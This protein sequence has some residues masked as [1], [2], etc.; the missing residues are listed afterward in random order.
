M[1][2]DG[3]FG[4]IDKAGELVIPAI[5]DHAFDFDRYNHAI[6]QFN[7]IDLNYFDETWF[8]INS[9]GDP[10]ISAHSILWSNGPI[11]ALQ[12][13]NEYMFFDVSNNTFLDQKS[14]ELPTYISGYAFQM[15]ESD[16]FINYLFNAD[17]ILI[18]SASNSESYLMPY[19]AH[20]HA[21][22]VVGETF[23]D[24]YADDITHRLVDK[25]LIGILK[26]GFMVENEHGIGVID[27]DYNIIID[28]TYDTLRYFDDDVYVFEQN[29]LLGILNADGEIIVEASFTDFYYDLNLLEK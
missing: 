5:F 10:I 27:F 25:T 29:Q 7:D 6:V 14:I 26:H 4:Y 2:I 21:L 8:L 11:Y 12:K 1:K 18:F 19:D 20:K 16:A 15:I 22:V 23:V 13:E 3:L 24:V 17:G 9:S 28:M